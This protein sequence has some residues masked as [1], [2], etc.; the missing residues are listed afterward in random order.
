LAKVLQCRIIRVGFTEQAYV[1][2]EV[3]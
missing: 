2:Y 1:M 3:Y